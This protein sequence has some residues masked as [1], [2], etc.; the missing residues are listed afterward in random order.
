MLVYIPKRCCI[1]GCGYLL[2]CIDIAHSVCCV[3]GLIPFFD[4]QFHSV[5]AVSPLPH[6]TCGVIGMWASDSDHALSVRTG[7]NHSCGVEHLLSFWKRA[8]KLFV[9]W[10]PNCVYQ[11][12]SERTDDFVIIIYESLHFISSVVMNEN[13]RTSLTGETVLSNKRAILQAFYCHKQ[14]CDAIESVKGKVSIVDFTC[15]RRNILTEICS[16]TDQFAVH[17]VSLVIALCS[18]LS[19]FRFSTITQYVLRYYTVKLLINNRCILNK[20]QPLMPTWH[21]RVSLESML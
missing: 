8:D 15:K 5:A 18:A 6:C 12:Q 13:G 20:W 7:V 21:R 3:T 10:N 16:R 2:G 19:T 17:F 4:N 11:Q 1:E 14:F 9:A